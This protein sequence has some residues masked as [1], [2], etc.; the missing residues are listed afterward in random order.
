VEVALSPAQDLVLAALDESG[1]AVAGASVFASEAPASAWASS[2]LSRG[3]RL[4]GLTDD[5][6]ELALKGET[7]GGRLAFVVTAGR[8]LGMVVLPMPEACDRPEDC[9]VVVSV[10]VPRPS[11]GVV[12]RRE[13]GEPVAPRDLTLRRGGL[14]IPWS[15]LTAVL[16]SNGLFVDEPASPLDLRVTSFLPDG[17]YS[18]TIQRPKIT[19]ETSRDVKWVEVPIG[20]FSVPSLGRVELVERDGVPAKPPDAQ[21]PRVA[22]R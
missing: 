20:S 10:A 12:V 18:A 6:G 4:A 16:F 11:A 22:E 2:P 19:P 15:I 21:A 14:P 5:A 17:L 13:S 7:Y 9:R 3:D 8:T 1:R